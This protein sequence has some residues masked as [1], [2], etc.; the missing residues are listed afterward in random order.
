[1]N[2]GKYSEKEIAIIKQNPHTPTVELANLLKRPFNGV[3]AK[4]RRLGQ[5]KVRQKTFWLASDTQTLIDKHLTHTSAEIGQ[6]IGKT[7]SQVCT[8]A[9]QLGLPI[10]KQLHTWKKAEIAQ[11]IALKNEGKRHKQ[12]AEILGLTV[13]AVNSKFSQVRRKRPHLFKSKNKS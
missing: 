10:K 5:K 3:L 1:M 6:M 4:R 13:R 8:K 2:T 9:T 12:I 11:L 7:T